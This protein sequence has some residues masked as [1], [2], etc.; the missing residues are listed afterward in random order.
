MRKE[1]SFYTINTVTFNELTAEQRAAAIAHGNDRD[2]L[3]DLGAYF[4]GYL[5]GSITEV[6]AT[7]LVNAVKFGQ[8]ISGC[9][10]V[11]KH[12]EEFKRT[13]DV[14]DLVLLYSED[15]EMDGLTDCVVGDKPTIT[16][17]FVPQYL[18]K[19]DNAQLLAHEND[20]DDTW[21]ATPFMLTYLSLAE[22]AGMEDDNEISRQFAND[23]FAPDWVQS[24]SGPFVVRV[25]ESVEAFFL[26]TTGKGLDDVTEEDYQ[27]VRTD[28][29][30]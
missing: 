27:A 5:S 16:A 25:R 10:V 15:D 23:S 7:R 20:D 8:P 1:L 3:I 18:D 17:Q 4:A 9:H 30:R 29:I 26:L 19:N 21:D 22:I 2:I 11:T 12:F 14:Q 24:Y 6:E 28:Y 13:L